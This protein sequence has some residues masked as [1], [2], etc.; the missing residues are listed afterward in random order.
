ML[1]LVTEGP[2]G[3]DEYA[4]EE[5]PDMLVDDWAPLTTPS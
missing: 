1:V 5:F 3:V 2:V 4:E